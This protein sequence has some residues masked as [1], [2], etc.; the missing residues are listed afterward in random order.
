MG[1][2]GLTVVVIV[3]TQILWVGIER[4]SAQDVR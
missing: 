2:G 1:Y 3:T 4:Y